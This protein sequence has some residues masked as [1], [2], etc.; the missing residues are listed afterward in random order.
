[1]T[2]VFHGVAYGSTN[3]RER[4]DTEERQKTEEEQGSFQVKEV[5]GFP[6]NMVLTEL[7]IGKLDGNPR[8]RRREKKRGRHGQGGTGTRERERE[9]EREKEKEREEERDGGEERSKRKIEIVELSEAS[10]LTSIS[11]SFS[12]PPS[13]SLDR[14]ACL[15]AVRD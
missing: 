8:V 12:L 11:L 4:E 14:R 1:M 3:G 10:F 2:I 5:S 7:I 15:T 13:F 9:G 6:D